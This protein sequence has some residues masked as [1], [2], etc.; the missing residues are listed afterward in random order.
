MAPPPPANDQTTSPL[1]TRSGAGGDSI[2]SNGVVQ[3]QQYHA[4][5]LDQ[6][7]DG[8]PT[9]APPQPPLAR[10]SLPSLQQYTIPSHPHSY[11]DGHQAFVTPPQTPSPNQTRNRP[12][13]QL[14]EH[15]PIPPRI[16]HQY[17]SPA[18][19]PYS[20][21]SG[22]PSWLRDPVSTLQG[23]S[24]PFFL[25]LPDGEANQDEHHNAAPFERFDVQSTVGAAEDAY[26]IA[27]GEAG[28][29]W[30]PPQAAVLRLRDGRNGANGRDAG[31]SADELARRRDSGYSEAN[32]L[33]LSS[34]VGVLTT[35]VSALTDLT[36]TLYMR[37]SFL[38]DSSLTRDRELEALRSLLI[39]QGPPPQRH[40]PHLPPPLPLGAP[41]LPRDY[42]DYPS[43]DG[44]DLTPPAS[45]PSLRHPHPHPHQPSFFPYQNGFDYSRISTPRSFQSIQSSSATRTRAHSVSIPPFG[46]NSHNHPGIGNGGG[47]GFLP[48]FGPGSPPFAFANEPAHPQQV[49]RASLGPFPAGGG[50]GPA[51]PLLVE[52]A[53]R[54]AME[55]RGIGPGPQG[56]G[57]EHSMSLANESSA[58]GGRPGLTSAYHACI[59][60]PGQHPLHDCTA[61]LP[62]VAPPRSSASSAGGGMN[63]ILEQLNYRLLL[64]NDSDIDSQAFVRRIL[65]N[66]D[67]QCS[68]FLQQRVR[69]TSP[70]RRVQLFE[71]A[72]QHVLDLAFSKFGNFLVS[73][74]LEAGDLQLAKTYEQSMSGHFLQLSLDPFGCHVVQKLLDC[75]DSLT[76]SKIIEEL[77]PHP[78][79][80]TQKNAGHVWNRVLNTSN[81][82]TLYR[83]LAEMGKGKWAEVVKDDGGSLIVQHILEDWAEAHTSLVAREVLEKVKEVA[84]TACG[85]FVL[86]R[87]IDRNALPFCSKIMQAAT[88]LALDNFGAK[89]VDKSVRTGRVPVATIAS[90]VDAIVAGDDSHPPLL[91]QIGSHVNGAQLIADLLTGGISAYR[92]KEKLVRGIA[93]NASILVQDGNPHG[94]KLVAMCNQA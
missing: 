64:E 76:K 74:C 69:T 40:P 53:L 10:N 75:G 41:P 50:G 31:V 36:D 43:S 57:R 24:T 72:G 6:P 12:P 59:R 81:P 82:P 91:V 20:N 17:F 32:L 11:V 33:Q 63:G 93:A 45:A 73:R 47:N 35:Q 3:D 71:A 4:P 5:G 68:L 58:V 27:N 9:L 34:T 2:G 90:F 49:R 84:R 79:A 26:N 62:N 37:L 29:T 18:P 30:A 48:P 77:M 22:D 44:G 52:Q 7:S 39:S 94:A 54:Q 66:N 83:R 78:S 42:Q 67:Q 86:S 80:L 65:V 60:S 23:R 85:S 61:S 1:Y 38:E 89:M 87:L 15:S 25:S 21:L 8:Q 16:G 88:Q 56:R 19:S 14:D 70:E 55:Q 51:P 46:A 13:R 92:D 28:R